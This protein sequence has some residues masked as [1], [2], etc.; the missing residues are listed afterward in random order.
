MLPPSSNSLYNI[1][2][3]FKRVELKPEVLF[4][5]SNAK[6]YVPR[7]EIDKEQ[8]VAMRIRFYGN[9]YTKAGKV[10]RIDAT[11]CEKAVI[12]AICEKQGWDDSRIWSRCT[13]KVQAERERIEVKIRKVGGEDGRA[14]G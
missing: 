3:R 10:K 4:W 14:G 1:F 11:N 7:W 6:G 9:W 2:W 5:K 8:K 12:D 13:G